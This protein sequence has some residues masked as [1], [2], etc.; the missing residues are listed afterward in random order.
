MNRHLL[1]VS[2]MLVAPNLDLVVVGASQAS[3]QV[4]SEHVG[5]NH[6]P[7]PDDAATVRV[8]P[9][10]KPVPEELK[11][12]P[13]P[14]PDD[15]AHMDHSAMDH[16]HMDHGGMAG[17]D[18]SGDGHAMAGALGPW[19]MTREASGTAWAPDASLH[20]HAVAGLGDW[21][22]SGHAL[23]NLSQT[24]Q[25]GPR[26]D[27]MAF[28]SGMVM[29]TA[30]RDFASGDAV[31][32]RAMLSPDPFMGKRGYPLLL[33][34]GETADGTT[35]L[36]DRRHPH[37]L[38][39]E[40]SGSYSKRLSEQD[41]AFVYLGL[42][43]E[44]A[45][46]PPAFM[47]REAAADSPEAPITHHWLDSTHITFGVATLGYAR[48]D[49]KIEAS[50]FH[51]REPDQHRF[52]IETGALDSTAVRVSWNPSAN[53]S[54]Q[55]SWAD[56]KSPE[57]IHPED[58]E[59]RWSAS[60]LYARDTTL[61]KVAATLAWGR[62]T[63]SHGPELD[64]FLVEMSVRPRPEWT[65]FARA[66]AERTD[67]LRIGL[68]DGVDDVGRLSL[69]AI[70]DWRLATHALLGLGAVVSRNW[71]GDALSTSYGGDRSSGT[72]FVRLKLGA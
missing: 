47:H 35:G 45:F 27:D 69:G 6:P 11:P 23:L 59:R 56:Q 15:H 36:H 64:A 32:F 46:G 22:L 10:P 1:V 42:P 44:P 29:G 26:G 61:G 5:H 70:R 50:R 28:A 33:A 65:L 58:D 57:Q 55:A 25:G 24:W 39:M 48:G 16:S 40:L 54:L 41:A 19:S 18:M 31:Q 17:M 14:A 72:V 8:P 43:G 7:P 66:E 60:A 13:A 62:R 52:D 49:W 63:A 21:T 20:Q 38:V 12:E 2:A 4:P 37:D 68:P 30:R 71:P 53:W 67:E 34:S 3:A 51:G 9:A